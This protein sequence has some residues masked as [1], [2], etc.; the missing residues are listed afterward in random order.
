MATQHAE[1]TP[2]PEVVPVSSRPRPAEVTRERKACDVSAGGV[3]CGAVTNTAREERHEHGTDGEA[4]WKPVT[5]DGDSL[6]NINRFPET[7]R[8][9]AGQ[10]LYQVQRGGRADDFKP[11]PSVGRGVEEIRIR[12]RTG[13]FRVIYTARLANA[14]YVLHAFQKKSQETPQHDID[15]AKSR[16]KALIRRLNDGA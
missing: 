4:D 10:Q 9:M 11:M 1:T 2:T 5:F 3:R 7:A 13:A 14:V 8:R 15:L 16:Y 6:K 12:D